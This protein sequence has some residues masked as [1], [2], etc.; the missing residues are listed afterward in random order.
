MFVISRPKPRLRRCE[1]GISSRT[2]SFAHCGG[3]R[4]RYPK[5]QTL[6]PGPPALFQL[7]A[8]N[9]YVAMMRVSK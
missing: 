6:K 8:P 4:M 1:G 3:Q 7:D 2:P 9:L 5:N